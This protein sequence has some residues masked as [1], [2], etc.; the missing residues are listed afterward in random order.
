MKKRIL[1]SG[2]GGS[3]FPYLHYKL[4]AASCE[5]YY[6]DSNQVLKY[7]YPDLNIQI[8]PLVSNQNYK[9]FIKQICIKNKI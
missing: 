2:L 8:A 9:E 4:I 5:L 7:I 6:V 3:L 1:I